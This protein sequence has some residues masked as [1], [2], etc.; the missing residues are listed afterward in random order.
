[1]RRERPALDR[2]GRYVAE[3]LPKSGVW[4]GQPVGRP[5]PTGPFNWLFLKRKSR[6]VDRGAECDLV[7]IPLHPPLGHAGRVC[8]GGRRLGLVVAGLLWTGLV[9]TTPS[10]APGAGGDRIDLRRDIQ[11]I[12]DASCTKCH[13]ATRQRSQ[14]RL[15]SRLVRAPRQRHRARDQPRRQRAESPRAG[16][17]AIPIRRS[18]CRSPRLRSRCRRRRSS[19]SAGGS[20]RAPPW[21]ESPGRRRYEPHWAY[22]DRS[23]A[24][25]PP[26]GA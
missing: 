22:R 16:R 9:V 26:R 10:E 25:E 18:A 11:P 7:A 24:P 19:S 15:D 8:L 21:P 4:R 13:G 20:T 12:F 3:G 1:M 17:L 2:P 14:L 23:L 6:K 5:V